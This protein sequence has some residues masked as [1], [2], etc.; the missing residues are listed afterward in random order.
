MATVFF[1]CIGVLSA[2]VSVHY[3]CASACGVPEG[4]VGSPGTG[5]TDC[6]E[7]P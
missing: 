5:V 2:R 4:G 1:M 6:C 3:T 7:Q